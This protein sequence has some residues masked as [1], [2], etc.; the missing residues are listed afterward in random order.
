M[1]VVIEIESREERVAAL[2]VLEREDEGY[3]SAP[4]NLFYITRRAAEALK[5][6]G[7]T[8][9]VIGGEQKE[10]GHVTSS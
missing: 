10:R 9:R 7:V 3:H 8:F 6:S 1:S 2:G 4:G 5:N